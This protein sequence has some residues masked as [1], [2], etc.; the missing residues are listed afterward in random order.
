VIS[1]RALKVGDEI[2][3]GIALLLLLDVKD[4]RVQ[5]VTLTGVRLTND[6]KTARV[7]FSVIGGSDVIQSAQSGLDSAKGFI[8][9]QI[10]LKLSLRY[11][12]EITFEHDPTLAQGSEMEKL[13]ESLDGRREDDDSR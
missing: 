2:L 10:G 12:P 5:D 1:K 6:L 4:P 13:F 9:R 11:V 7:Y 8:K 3:K